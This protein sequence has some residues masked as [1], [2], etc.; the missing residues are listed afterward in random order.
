MT[1]LK[2]FLQGLFSTLSLVIISALIFS[3]EKAT[4]K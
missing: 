3:Y 1:L 2:T 4:E